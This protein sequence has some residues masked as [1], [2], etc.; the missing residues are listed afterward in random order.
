MKILFK[1]YDK[2]KFKSIKII[3]DLIN[4]LINDLKF[5]P[6]KLLQHGYLFDIHP[7]HIKRLM[8][9]FP[10][11]GGEDIKTVFFRYPKLITIPIE[12][13]YEISKYLKVS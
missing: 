8:E 4:F 5:T 7:N 9:H 11:L 2:F 13:F 10:K 3:C 6:K 12:N 1:T